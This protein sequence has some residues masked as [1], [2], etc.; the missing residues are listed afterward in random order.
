M[1]TLLLPTDFS[2]CA[3]H[4]AEYGYNLARQINAS[5][6]LCNAVI[7]PAEMPQAG[8]VV[9]PMDEFDL[10]LDASADALKHVKAHLENTTSKDGFQPSISCINKA[11]TV[12]DVVNNI[13]ASGDID[14]VLTGTHG[15][16]GMSTFLLG[17]HSRNMIDG[18]NKPLILVPPAAQIAPAKRIAFSTDLKHPKNDLAS[19]YVLISIARLLDAEILVTHIY[20][21][22]FHSPEYH[23][24]AKQSLKELT[25]HSNYPKIYYKSFKNSQTIDGLNWLCLHEQIDMLA[26]VHRQHNFLDNLLKGSHT[27][28]MAGH[29]SIP[30]LVFPSG[31]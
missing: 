3:T 27:Q 7:V 18:I 15:S 28:K 30:L 17:N 14:L 5:V 9:W 16:S 1:K 23:E 21:E 26:M 29:L 19:F 13:I 22:K 25:D 31:Q 24:W 8:L 10:L 6:I 4:A 20:N 12:T 2:A 11:G